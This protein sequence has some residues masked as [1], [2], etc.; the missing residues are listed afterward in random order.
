MPQGLEAGAR[1]RCLGFWVSH[2]SVLTREFRC[3]EE[4]LLAFQHSGI[5]LLG[6]LGLLHSVWKG[7]LE[8]RESLFS[9][10]PSKFHS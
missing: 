9:I 2:P 3:G 5:C 6:I 10:L 4:G 8:F 7:C 1:S